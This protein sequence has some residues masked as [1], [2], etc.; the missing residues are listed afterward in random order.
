MCPVSTLAHKTIRTCHWTVPVKTP[1]FWVGVSKKSKVVGKGGRLVGEV[2]ETWWLRISSCWLDAR[3][4]G[5]F[6]PHSLHNH[7]YVYILIMWLHQVGLVRDHI[8]WWLVIC[9]LFELPRNRPVSLK[10]RFQAKTNC[11]HPSLSLCCTCMIGAA[12]YPTCAAS[13]S[14]KSTAWLDETRSVFWLIC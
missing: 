2:W 3:S 11:P 7:C 1:C 13:V 10:K 6:L 12:R 5:C 9:R 8:S 4:R 14:G